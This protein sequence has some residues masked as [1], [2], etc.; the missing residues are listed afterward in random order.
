MA[1][2]QQFHENFQRDEEVKSSS[3]RVFGLVFSFAFAVIGIWP[4]FL[5]KPLRWWSLAV[6]LV[7][8]GLAI[9]SPQLLVPLNRAWTKL[10]MMMHRVVNPVIMGFL[11]FAVIMPTGLVLRLIG[12]DLL[13]LKRDAGA[14]TY[15]IERDPP[16][17]PPDG[18][19]KQF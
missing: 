17:P 4:A 18:M 15:W 7:L 6:S 19:R 10:G 13:R 9:I 1:D 11:F 2:S 8:L 3:N 16:G 12:K 5:G 14:E